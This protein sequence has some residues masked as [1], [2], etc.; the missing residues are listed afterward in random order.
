[1]TRLSNFPARGRI[2]C[3]RQTNARQGKG[4]G[5][6]RSWQLRFS[7]SPS[8]L[9]IPSFELRNLTQPFFLFD[10]LFSSITSQHQSTSIVFIITIAFANNLRTRNLVLNHHQPVPTNSHVSLANF[11]ISTKYSFAMRR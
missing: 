2:G 9:P 5:E 7:N 1:V 11:P 10:F 6:Q 3:P 8:F 4:T